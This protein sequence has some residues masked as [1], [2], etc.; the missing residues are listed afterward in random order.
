MS[1]ATSLGLGVLQI[2]VGLHFLAGIPESVLWQ[3]IILAAMD[4]A[5]ITSSASGLERGINFLSTINLA[6]ALMSYVLAVD[7]T[8]R[9]LEII[10]QRIGDCLQNFFGMSLRTGPWDK[11]RWAAGWAVFYWARVIAWSPFAGAFVARISRGRTIK[12]H[13]FGVVA[14]PP[15]F[16]C[17]WF[18]VFGGAA[19]HCELERQ[20]GLGAAVNENIAT[21]LF[22]L[23]D[24]MPLGALPSVVGM[25]LIFIFL[26]T[27]ADSASYIVAQMTDEGCAEPPLAKRVL[28]GLLIAAICLTLVCCPLTGDLR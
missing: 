18:G 16:A 2:N 24:L 15:L 8:L 7:P 21:V 19:L 27:S 26:V 22:K 9:V 25:A 12:E 17:L 20:A 14:T 4:A 6:L 28:W 3:A 11:S 1:V 13:V 23:F 5:L 10:V